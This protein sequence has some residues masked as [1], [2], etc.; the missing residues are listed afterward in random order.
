MAKAKTP[1]KKRPH[2]SPKRRAVEGGSKIDPARL[3]LVEQMLSACCTQRD[4][5]HKVMDKFK[6]C[7]VT[8][9]SYYH[10]VVREWAAEEKPKRAYHRFKAIKTLDQAITGAVVDHKWSAIAR[11]VEVKA[12]LLGLNEPDEVIVHAPD[13]HPTEGMTTAQIRAYIT[14]KRETREKLLVEV[15]AEPTSVH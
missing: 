14:E 10:R 11:L 4:I 3:Q 5:V 13:S 2:K 12:K 15:L 9:N 7:K 1:R 8:A 6:V